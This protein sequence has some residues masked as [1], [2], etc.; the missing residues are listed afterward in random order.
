MPGTPKRNHDSD[1]PPHG[2]LLK[3]LKPGRRL[4]HQVASA[5][6]APRGHACN[7]QRAQ[8]ER[9]GKRPLRWTGN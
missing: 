2:G 4:S 8:K 3:S 1:N 9:A 6:A 5:I 7:K